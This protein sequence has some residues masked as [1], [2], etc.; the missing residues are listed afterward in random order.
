[1]FIR[2]DTQLLKID[3]DSLKNMDGFVIKQK[4]HK[5]ETEYY[6]YSEYVSTSKV[7]AKFDTLD[8]AKQALE[9]IIAGV[10][11]TLQLID[12]D[13]FLVIKID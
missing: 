11:K 9:F 7:V 3:V 2:T 13:D 1:M 4:T 10:E 5:E 6:L 8:K 12:A